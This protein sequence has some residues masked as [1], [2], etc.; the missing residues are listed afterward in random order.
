M[1]VLL[2]VLVALS[3]GTADFVGG[4]ATA[5]SSVMGTLVVSQVCAFT[6]AVLLV[7][8]TD[9]DLTAHDIVLGAWAGVAT[10]FGIGLLYYGLAHYAVGVVAPI[11]AVTG[12]VVPVT[13]GLIQGERPSVLAIF[14]V[15]L[16]ISAGALI[17][18]E[19][20]ESHSGGTRGVTVAVLAG[21]TLGASL[22][23]F[24]E[25]NPDSGMWPVLSARAVAGLLV[26]LGA[27]LLLARHRPVAMTHDRDVRLAIAAGTLDVGATALLVL[28]VRR[29]LIVVVAPIASLAPGFT[30]LLAWAV[31]G[32]RL[33]SVQRVGV[34][35]A[36]VGVLLVS[37]G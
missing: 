35:C 19:R 8:V 11:A 20:D 36:L 15:V 21:A 13:W 10:I 1:A 9:A 30:V 12:A 22:V 4:R 33:G 18:R 24:A 23:L 37:T 3:F 26:W 16:A 32:E 28:A 25:T 2:G 6:G 7:L 14:G 17:A 5:R 27:L 31:L 29:G 34:V